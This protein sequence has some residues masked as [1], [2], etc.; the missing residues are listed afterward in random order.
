MS[1]SGTLDDLYF[2]W[3][4]KQ[5]GVVRNRNPS[6]SHWSL[7]KQLY[8]KRFTWFVR[9]DGNRAEDGKDLRAEF[10]DQCDIQDVDYDWLTLDCSVLEVLIALSRRVAFE[11]MDARMHPAEWFWTLMENIDLRKYTDNHYDRSALI[12][13]DEALDRVLERT[14]RR[15]GDGGL[16]PLRNEHD[17]QRRIELWYQMSSYLLERE[18]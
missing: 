18:Y 10:I 13:I 17:D 5:V 16:F 1:S 2:E 7:T 15:N 11:S 9:N 6:K 14:Y 3:L 8:S 12:K 4:Y